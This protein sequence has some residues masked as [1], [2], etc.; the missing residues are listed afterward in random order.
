[1]AKELA[2]WGGVLA[3]AL[4]VFVYFHNLGSDHASN[5]PDEIVYYQ[6]ARLTAESGHWLPL[7]GSWK[8]DRNTK[9]PALFW[10]GIVS[11][12]WARNWNLWNIRYPNVLYTI[13]IAG[14]VFLLA[15]KLG[16]RTEAGILAAMVY[17]AF[18]G[19]YRYGRV[20]MTSAPETF[21]LFLPFFVLLYW[22]HRPDALTWSLAAAFGLL[23]GIGLL[24]KSFALVIPAAGALAW[25]T[26]HERGYRLATWARADLAKVALFAALAL[27]V[28]G[29]WFVL[30]PAPEE[31]FKAFILRE[32]AGKFDAKDG[33][34]LFNF[35]AGKYSIWRIVV[36]YPLNAGLLAPAIVAL[37]VISWRRRR[38]LGGAEKLLWIWVATLAIFFALP[39]QRDERYLLP[40]MPALAVLC[41]L[42]WRAIPRWVLGIGLVACAVIALGMGVGSAILT[43][44]FGQGTIYPWYYWAVIAGTIVFAL[45]ALR[46]DR[47]THALVCPA[48]FLVYFCYAAFLHP[49]DGP[50]GTYGPEAVAFAKGRTVAL[51]NQFGGAREEVQRFMLPG[52]DVQNVKGKPPFLV[53][54]LKLKHDAFIISLP[55]RDMTAENTPDIRI[56]GYR[57][58]FNDRPNREENAMIMRGEFS[59]AMFKKDLLI[60]VIGGSGTRAN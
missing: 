21:W 17:L 30:D 19:T 34:Y 41:A 10:Q 55:L 7:Q 45:S 1:M 11:T 14:M 15:R 9:P 24:Y 2:G 18:F 54:D 32:N 20:F 8:K 3:L 47:W 57:L 49:F 56:V 26:L 50:H 22:R 53:D 40:G 6:I 27:G 23:V 29:L 52:C 44:D 16:G 25:W 46:R 4:G 58:N 38:E 39:N 60:E 48:I 31:V 59:P 51:P 33:S 43:R 12:D 42:H 28:F 37:F 5:N 36:A 35:F 13:A